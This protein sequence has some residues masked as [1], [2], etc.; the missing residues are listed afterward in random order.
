MSQHTINMNDKEPVIVVTRHK[1]LVEFLN[2]YNLLPDGYVHMSHVNDED[3]IRGCHVIG[4]LPLHLA[5][6]ASKVTEVKLN[7]PPK[8]RGKELTLR[9]TI[10]YFKGMYTYEVKKTKPYIDVSCDNCM[11]SFIKDHG[12]SNYTVEGAENHCVLG[13]RDS[14]DDWYGMRDTELLQEMQKTALKCSHFRPKSDTH[15]ISRIDVD[16]EGVKKENGNRDYSDYCTNPL[17]AMLLNKYM[18][19]PKTGG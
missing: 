2:V 9:E 16:E 4:V 8:M 12:Y 6:A 10:K 3:E 15:Y 18:N 14:F 17:I 7:I 5:A 11:Y 19:E 1:A 13:Q